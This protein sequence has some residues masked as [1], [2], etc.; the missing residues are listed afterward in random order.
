MG[1][2]IREPLA[3]N[4]THNK[5]ARDCEHVVPCQLN[6]RARCAAKRLVEPTFITIRNHIAKPFRAGQKDASSIPR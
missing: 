4:F 6:E 3:I 1:L 5:A 2:T